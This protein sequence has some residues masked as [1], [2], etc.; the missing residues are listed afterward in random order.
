MPQRLPYGIHFSHDWSFD[1]M[2]IHS[3]KSQQSLQLYGDYYILI[4][5]ATIFIVSS[6]LSMVILVTLLT[7]LNILL[8]TIFC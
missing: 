6:T 5:Y 2:C 4:L 7:Y 1:Q 3:E 8:E